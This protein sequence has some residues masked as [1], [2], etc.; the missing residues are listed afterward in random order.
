VWMTTMQPCTDVRLF[1]LYLCV[2]LA[3]RWSFSFAKHFAWKCIS[4]PALHWTSRPVPSIVR[5]HPVAAHGSQSAVADAVVRE[6]RTIRLQLV[7]CGIMGTAGAGANVVS[8][9]QSMDP[10]ATAVG[11]CIGLR[12]ECERQREGQW[13]ATIGARD[14]TAKAVSAHS[15]DASCAS[16]WRWRT[17]SCG[18]R[19]Q[20]GGNG[21]G[22]SG[23]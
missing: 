13:R 2:L 23:K 12:E 10:G 6:A 16:C 22:G 3:S 15:G 20:A 9:S 19:P 11:W 18:R 1:A 8:S 7:S 4:C 21:G 17:A 14:H 5:S